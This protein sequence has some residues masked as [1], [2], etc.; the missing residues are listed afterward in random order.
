ML[1]SPTEPALKA[2]TTLANFRG[3]SNSLVDAI[4]S[5]GRFSVNTRYLDRYE[6]VQ[7]TN[8]FTLSLSLFRSLPHPEIRTD[9]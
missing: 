4:E 3:H 2:I 6:F 7:D 5:L 9:H 8:H 1:N